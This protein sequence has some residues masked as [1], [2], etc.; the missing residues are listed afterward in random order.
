M[1]NFYF[2]KI[3]GVV[4]AFEYTCDDEDQRLDGSSKYT[5]NNIAPEQFLSCEEIAEHVLTTFEDEADVRDFKQVAYEDLIMYHHSF[6]RWIRNTYGLWHPKNPY[7]IAG[8][9][10]DGHPD[11]LSMRA[12]KLAHQILTT[13]TF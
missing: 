2:L 3:D 9:T 7:V 10:G 13:K 8:D 5:W 1:S 4:T 11:G 6:G 12:I